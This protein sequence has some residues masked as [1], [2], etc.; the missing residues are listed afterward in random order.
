[1]IA[2][3]AAKWPAK[4]K[5]IITGSGELEKDVVCDYMDRWGA[6]LESS[7]KG[8]SFTFILP[9]LEIGVNTIV[10]S[11]MAD[12]GDDA[13]SGIKLVEMP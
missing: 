2:H 5:I 10:N 13:I 12:M 8:G 6:K 1:M 4:F 9:E 7:G 3:N 11:M